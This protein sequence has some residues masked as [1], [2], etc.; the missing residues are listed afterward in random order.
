M[1]PDSDARM[2]EFGVFDKAEPSRRA[3]RE[4][5]MADDRLKP[6][7]QQGIWTNCLPSEWFG[8]NS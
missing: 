2:L 7:L 8:W 6:L 1:G 4:P 5:K 3:P